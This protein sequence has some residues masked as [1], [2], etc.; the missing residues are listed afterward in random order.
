MKTISTE[1]ERAAEQRTRNI[2]RRAA[3]RVRLASYAAAR[4]AYLERM[5]NNPTF[6]RPQAD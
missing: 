5:A 3:Y 4:L 2:E 6:L 1:T